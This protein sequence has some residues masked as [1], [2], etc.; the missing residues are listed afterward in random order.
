MRHDYEDGE[1][2]EWIHDCR[3][4]VA[5]LRDE[6]DAAEN[7]LASALHEQHRLDAPPDDGW[8]DPLA[9]DPTPLD[10]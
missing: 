3:A 7:A 8:G 6:L 2:N 4:T 1:L 10:L 5:R 9:A